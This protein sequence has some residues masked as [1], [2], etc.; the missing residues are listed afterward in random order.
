MAE[1]FDVVVIGGGPAGYSAAICAAR[2]SLRT[3]LVEE[4]ELGGTCLNRGCIPTKAYLDTAET[5]R[6]LSHAAKR[7]IDFADADVSHFGVSMKQ[8]LAFKTRVVR[9]MT[10][11]VGVLLRDNGIDR[12]HGT[13]SIPALP[14]KSDDPFEIVVKGPDATP[15]QTTVRAKKVILAT[16]SVPAPL[17]IAGAEKP[18]IA[19]RMLTSDTLLDIDFV[20][21]KLL[22]VGAGVIGIEMARIFK[23]FGSDV[24]L[25]EA[26][27]RIAPFLD[28]EI[29]E[30]L[31]KSL[32]SA[33]IDITTGLTVDSVAYCQDDDTLSAVPLE[34][35]LS[36]GR[37][38]EASHVLVAVGRVPDR[39]VISHLPLEK[40]ARA[41]FVQTDEEMRTSIPG[42]FAAGDVNGRSMLAHAAIRMGHC[43]AVTAAG[44]LAG[45]NDLIDVRHRCGDGEADPLFRDGFSPPFIPGCIY[46]EPEIG[47][48]G[49]TEAQAR[50]HFGDRVH[51]GRFPFAANGRAVAVGRQEGF[52]KVLRDETTDRILGVHIIGTGASELINEASL[53]LR[54]SLSAHSWAT[55]VHAHP[56]FGEA[57]AE[58]VADARGEA[59]HIPPK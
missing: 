24:H 35:R 52:V 41:D 1:L 25:V 2:Y 9:K 7:G 45:C 11:G 13:A 22:I 39:R 19:V 55:A 8:V 36:D 48:I 37:T 46:G 54:A 33:K 3:A 53:A 26:L 51:I 42:I 44:D 4:R 21:P 10:A 34:L 29:V 30:A 27:P 32:R 20:P 16:G 43:A 47:Y 38:L 28:E 5:L 50:E 58:A 12:F 23:A 18:E 59:L 15:E 57:L 31:H 56:T 17:S 6:S 49:L 40:Y 14:E